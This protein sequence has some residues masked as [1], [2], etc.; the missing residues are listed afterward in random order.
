MAS[1]SMGTPC[2]TPPAAL[3]RLL[4]RNTEAVLAYQAML[5]R[6]TNATERDFRQR[7]RQALTRV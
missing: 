7:S 5:T 6:T 4:D 2:S 3:L 1:T